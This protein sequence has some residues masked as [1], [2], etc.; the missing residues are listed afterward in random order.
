MLDFFDSD[1]LDKTEFESKLDVSNKNM[2]LI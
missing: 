1:N 2:K